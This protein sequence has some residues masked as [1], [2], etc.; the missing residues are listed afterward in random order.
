MGYDQ[1]GYM[2]HACTELYFKSTTQHDDNID[3]EIWLVIL[4]YSLSIKQIQ[5]L[6]GTV[7]L[8][9]IVGKLK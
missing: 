5:I 6:K 4:M 9:R 3:S 1:K 2:M 8:H 7:R